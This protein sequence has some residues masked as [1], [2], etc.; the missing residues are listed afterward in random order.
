VNDQLTPEI[1]QMAGSTIRMLAADAVQKANS[2]HPGLPMG[3][4][5]CAYVLWSRILKYNPQD[6][7]WPNRDRFVLSA[8]HGSMLLYA[9]LHLAGYDVTLED[10]QQFRQW[11]SRT[12]GHPERDCLPG[13][14]TTTGPLGQGFANGVGMA[15]AAKMTGARFN[16]SDFSPVTHHVF[17]IVSDGDL[18]EGVTGEAASLAGHLGLDNLVYL[19]DNNQITI[20]GETSLTFSEDVA[21]RFDAYGWRTHTID[22]HDHQAI[23]KALE[24][25]I[26][27]TQ[28]PTLILAKTHIAFG[29]PNKQD[30][31]ASHGAPLGEEEIALTKKNLDW[32]EEPAFHVPDEVRT[33]FQKRAML[34]KKEYDAWQADFKKWRDANPKLANLWDTMQQKTV[35]QNLEKQLVDVLPDKTM[36]TRVSSGLVLQKAAALFPGLCGGSADLSPSTKTIIEN[37]SSILANQFE[38]R[39]IHFGIREHGMGGI[40]NGMALYGGFI[41]YGSTFFVFSDYMRP[42]IRLASLMNLQVIFVFT[43]DSLFVGEDG[44][45][46]QPVEQ[47]AALRTVPGLAVIRPADGVETAAAWAYALRKKDGPTA[48]CLTRQNV[49]PIPRGDNFSLA[50]IHKG[51]YVL[52]ESLSESC[53]AILAASGSEVSLALEAQKGLKEK[54]VDVRVVSMPCMSLFAEQDDS[55]KKSIIPENIPI[56]VIEAGI[57]QG[58][59][60]LTRAP[61]LH[62]GMNQFGASAPAKVLAEKFGFT[63]E[64]VVE[65]VGEWLRT[66]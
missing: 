39:N 54:G 45:T 33:V 66:L 30:T 1:D 22:G 11:G 60:A 62:I 42:S 21:K 44:P 61:I 52:S 57:S 28:K 38:G 6:P 65:R 20:E 43:H 32:P 35:P 34:L 23:Q 51:G 9:M 15:L 18:M 64:L 8:G 56:V 29:S 7:Q 53:H 2:G 36:A 25:G 40:L 13:V 37:D 48:L 47:L 5:D 41:P 59:H 55:Y 16:H 19:Y 50:T 10:I 3:M 58:L 49:P 46:H 24:E 17:G 4:A 27:T 31:A 12:P 63:P 26:Q 14:E